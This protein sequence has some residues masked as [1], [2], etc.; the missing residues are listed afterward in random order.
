M[1]RPPPTSHSCVFV[2][3]FSSSP[4]NLL[5]VPNDT[6]L[7]EGGII[8]LLKRYQFT[9][10][11]SSARDIQVALDPE[12]LGKV[13]ENLLAEENE[14]TKKAARKNTGSFYTPRKIVDYMIKD[15][16]KEYLKNKTGVNGRRLNALFNDAENEDLNP[17][18]REAVVEA[19]DKMKIFDPAVGSGA[20]LMGALQELIS[21]LD[22][23]D[24]EHILYK[25]RQLAK[26]AESTNPEMAQ[27]GI[28]EIFQNSYYGRKQQLLKSCLH[29][30]D[31]QP[32]AIQICKLRFFIS[33][34]VEQNASTD[35]ENNFGIQPLPNLEA[36]FVAADTLRSMPGSEQSNLAYDLI[37]DDVE[38][39]RAIRYEYFNEHNPNNKD[40]LR[41]RDQE[42]QEEAMSK[43]QEGKWGIE[44]EIGAIGHDIY[45]QHES[46]P[47]FDSSLMFGLREGYDLVIGNPP[48]IPLRR[49]KSTLKLKYKDCGYRVYE[50]LGD[51]YQLFYEKGLQLL[52]EG[53]LLCFITSNQWMKAKYG[54]KMRQYLAKYEDP[55]KLINLGSRIFEAAAVNTNI[56]MIRK[57]MVKKENSVQVASLI[58]ETSKDID[59]CRFNKLVITDKGEGWSLLDPTERAIKRRMEEIGTPLKEWDNTDCFMG[60]LTGYDQAFVLTKQEHNNLKEELKMEMAKIAKPVLR[61]ERI[62]RKYLIGEPQELLLYIPWHFP[63]VDAG[64]SGA[65]KQ[66][67]KEFSARCPHLYNYLSRHKAALEK[68]SEAGSRHEW[69]TLKR[70]GNS[71]QA[72][73]KIVWQ[74]IATNTPRFAYAREEVF[75]LNSAVVITTP[76]LFYLL[77]VL[78]SKMVWHYIRHIV[79]NIS[80]N[81]GRL[82]SG[83]I[84]KIPVPE[85]DKAGKVAGEISSFV[86]EAIELT[87]AGNGISKIEQEINEKVF[88]LYG[89]TKKEMSY[90]NELG[91]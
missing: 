70:W 33:L 8:T 45:S 53:G 44:E 50:G 86:E 87:L 67:E 12:L 2:D 25:E 10:E 81:G 72:K 41:A 76:N 13:F 65:S 91:H 58:G 35:K 4:N 47:W 6:M 61:G 74:E 73:K 79:T 32:I 48:Y 31:I 82:T 28:E 59:R 29:G 77:G 42:I 90:F 51:I 3:G 15:S 22:K 68:R 71:R 56:L 89:L 39:L 69:Y 24:P 16:L 57:G 66:A 80:E 14:E 37:A 84:K 55:I 23:V 85:M 52:K 18:E 27:K 54:K 78:N 75:V 40:A 64:I 5:K 63:L 38:E 9:V 7:G 1:S 83:P 88:E 30:V 26:T 11:E 49:N 21:I 62:D 36:K 46:S 60:I 17:E 34:I 19:I 20:F 43:L